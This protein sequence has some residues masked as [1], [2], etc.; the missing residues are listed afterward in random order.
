MPEF[1]IFDNNCKLRQHLLSIGEDHFQDTALPVDVF[2][3]HTKHKK[4]DIACNLHCN[5]AAFP[6]LYDMSENKWTVNSSICE[7]TNSWF[8]RYLPIVREM[9][10]T[11]FAFY[12][13]EMIKRKN[14]VIVQDL[15]IQGEKP[16]ICDRNVLL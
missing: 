16:W 14:R 11:R 6:E 8:G 4:E 15:K 12:L 9:E 7:E 1:L 2:H 5:P 13:D 3:F 10:G